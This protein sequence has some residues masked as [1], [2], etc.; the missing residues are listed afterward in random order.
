[1]GEGLGSSKWVT[2]GFTAIS[3]AT[4]GDKW[5]LAAPVPINL[6]R[7][8]FIVA[9]GVVLPVDQGIVALDKRVQAG[10][11]VNRVEAWGGT[12]T[13][14][15]TVPRGTQLYNQPTTILQL[16]PGEEIVFEVTD[17]WSAGSVVFAVEYLQQP[18]VKPR[19]PTSFQKAV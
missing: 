5:G 3:V 6:V 18:F 11:D 9:G 16:N 7:W 1:M 12:I 19:I 15:A 17:A 2:S 10:S 8:G 4:L 14:A 13:Q